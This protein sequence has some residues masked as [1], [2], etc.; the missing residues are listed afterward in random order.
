MTSQAGTPLCLLGAHA[1][2]MDDPISIPSTVIP[3]SGS[4]TP[5]SGLKG[6][7]MHALYI[8]TCRQNTDTCKIKAFFLKPLRGKVS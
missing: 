1:V 4:R 8:Q 2:L 5:S 3:G 6:T 7:C